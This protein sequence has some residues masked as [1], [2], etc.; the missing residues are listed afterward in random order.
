MIEVR[1]NTETKKLTAWCGDEA[2]FGNLAREGH[3]LVLLDTP[4]PD[5]P[6]DAWL[7]DEATQSLVPN[8]DYQPPEEDYTWAKDLLENP[9]VPITMPDIWRL[10]RLFGKLLLH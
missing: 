2:Q 3:T 9:P 4:I 1:Y 7:Y 10:I 5:R 6:L 8:P